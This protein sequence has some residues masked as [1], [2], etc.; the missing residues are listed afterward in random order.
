[1]G[2]QKNG[3]VGHFK[4]LSLHRNTKERSKD[5]QNNFV[6]TVEISQRFTAMKL[7]MNQEESDLKP[8]KRIMIAF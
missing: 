4:G 3:I 8:S 1:M 6:E 2:H 5:S 7:T